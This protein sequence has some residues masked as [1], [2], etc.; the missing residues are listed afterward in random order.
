MNRDIEKENDDLDLEQ[1]EGSNNYTNKQMSIFLKW[2]ENS[3][4]QYFI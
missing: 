2:T 4:S 3:C 1:F